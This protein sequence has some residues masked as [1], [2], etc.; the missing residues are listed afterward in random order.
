MSQLLTDVSSSKVP[1]RLQ[2]LSSTDAGSAGFTRLE[3]ASARIVI[4]RLIRSG[5]RRGPSDYLILED[6]VLEKWF[7]EDAVAYLHECAQARKAREG[8]IEIK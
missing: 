4:K 8:V 7:D 6:H 2:R 3:I 1:T 5:L